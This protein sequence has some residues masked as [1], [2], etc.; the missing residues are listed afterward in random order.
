M[1]GESSHVRVGG[2]S[3]SEAANAICKVPYFDDKNP[4]VIQGAKVRKINAV[5]EA[6]ILTVLRIDESNVVFRLTNPTSRSVRLPSAGYARSDLL[7]PV[8]TNPAYAIFHGPELDV[9]LFLTA[10]WRYVGTNWFFA[11]RKQWEEHLSIEVLKPGNHL[12]LTREIGAW[13]ATTLTDTNLI[14]R[15]NFQ[16]AQDWAERYKIWEGNLSA[17][18]FTT[19]TDK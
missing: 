8:N 14:L 11:S 5:P 13:P 15:F 1:I 3:T 10:D 2:L 7:I 9:G 16:I 4:K 6:L 18:G 19:G 17:T 12:D